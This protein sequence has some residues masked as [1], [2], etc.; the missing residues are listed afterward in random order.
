[1]FAI[2]MKKLEMSYEKPSME[3]VVLN[4]ESIVCVSP[5]HTEPTE[6][7]EVEP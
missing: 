3:V 7:E 2:F 6:D 1:M 5:G 4:A